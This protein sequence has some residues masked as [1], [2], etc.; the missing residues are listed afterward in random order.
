MPSLSLPAAAY[1]GGAAGGGTSGGSAGAGQERWATLATYRCQ[2]ATNRL[3]VAFRL[4]EGLPGAELRAVAVPAAAPK[5]CAG[6]V[7]CRLPPLCLHQRVAGD[8][9]AAYDLSQQRPPAVSFSGG[10]AGA[11]QGGGAAA[12]AAAAASGGGQQAPASSS[13]AAALSL[14]ALRG[15]FTLAE[16]HAWAAACLPDLPPRPPGGSG[17]GGA[18]AGSGTS[19]GGSWGFS[20]GGALQQ[21][22]RYSFR[23]ARTGAALGC[24]LAAGAA[25]FVAEDVSALALLHDALMAAATAARAR[26]DASLEA[27]PRALE[28]A[29]ALLWPALARGAGRARR[30]AL[31]A[32][33]RELRA[34]EDGGDVSYLAPEYARLLREGDGGGADGGGGGS[35]GD[36]ARAGDQR[37]ASQQGFGGGGGGRG[38]G[39][40][41]ADDAAATAAGGESFELAAARAAFRRLHRDWRRLA[42]GAGTGGAGG[43]A[44]ARAAGLDALLARAGQPGAGLDD[45]VAYMRGA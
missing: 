11:S 18:G 36:A 28:R 2:G 3:A 20:G 7:V 38:T 10:T 33:L 21:E 27:H 23:S 22:V 16:A 39:A 34:Q 29:A 26:V 44:K 40:A 5:A 30:A 43:D 19:G 31:L 42:G 9:L 15:S 13:S 4:D 24:G 8:V 6:A 1:G 45:I 14:L 25:R 12:A 17:G 32:A 41:A 35:G 37:G